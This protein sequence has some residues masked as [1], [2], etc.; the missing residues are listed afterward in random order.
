[1]AEAERPR[2]FLRAHAG[3][4]LAL[5]NVTSVGI[6]FRLRKGKRT[7]E[8][9]L[10]FSVDRKLTA[11]GLRAQGLSALPRTIAV[12]GT[13]MPVD[14]V[15]RRFTLSHQEIA[16]Q[17]L[18][19]PER[20][21]RLERVAPGCSIGH[22]GLSAGTLGAVVYDLADGR[23]CLLGS[24][25]ALQGQ[26][27][28]IG[29]DAVQPGAFD[30]N[31]VH[32][33]RIGTLLRSHLGAA[34]DFAL[35]LPEDR[36]LEPA[37]LGL[38]VT[39]I[40]V[41]RP[42]LGDLVVK[43]GRTTGVTYGIVTRTDVMVMLA[44][45][46]GVGEV[47][48]G[49]FEI[50][51][52]PD[53]AA[54]DGV[55][56]TG[57]DSGAAWLA[58]GE[59]G[60]AT[61]VMLGLQMADA[62]GGHALAAHAHAAMEKLEVQLKPRRAAALARAATGKGFDLKFLSHKVPLPTAGPARADDVLEVKGQTHVA[63]THYS[64]SMSRSR[65]LALWVAWNID[66]KQFKSFGRKGLKFVFDPLIDEKAQIGDELYARNRLDR[67]HIARRA[68]LVWGPDAEAQ[69]ANR[70]S[71][72]FSNI[73]PQHQA[74][75]QSQAGGLWGELEN[76]IFEDVDVADIRISVMGGPVLDDEDPLYRDVKIP[77]SFWKIIAYFDNTPDN[78]PDSAPDSPAD[79]DDAR[80]AKGGPPAKGGQFKV[81]GYVLT[82]AD[83][84]DRM[85]ILEL[86]PFKLYRVPLL[87]IERQTGLDFG[88]LKE[89][90]D[91]NAVAAAPGAR[92]D[93]TAGITEITSRDQILA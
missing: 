12:D 57:G 32:S 55:I 86:D 3:D 51:P 83:L 14:I 54:P 69:Q 76:A 22:A 8:R 40:E 24:W 16:A 48:V 66:G 18:R 70:E 87:E 15:E 43:S 77:R 73:T 1:M 90:D 25:H 42:E 44:Y 21:Q 6:G 67:G 17:D 36:E 61:P 71:F 78:A 79:G 4:W 49:A 65:R 50:G 56:A 38:D 45:G 31:R 58:A 27:G 85:E 93:R 53:H 63:H 41:A 7:R 89:A 62:G 72:Y 13:E 28:R 82:Q 92:A 91:R 74:F 60:K 11:A 64:L 19:K 52:S 80:Q 75:N 29:D 59:D 37:I 88:T 26:A 46:G 30:D 34:G 10:Q 35:V 39:P 47:A 33:N 68:D 20:K 84:L 5:P 81:K 2:A 9:C 23:P